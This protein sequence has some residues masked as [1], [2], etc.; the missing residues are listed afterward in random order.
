MVQVANE[1]NSMW[2]EKFVLNNGLLV[3]DACV[4]ARNFSELSYSHTKVV[5]NLAKLAVIFPICVVWM[6]DVPSS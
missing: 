4:F 3:Q 2:C 1:I 5:H 6:E